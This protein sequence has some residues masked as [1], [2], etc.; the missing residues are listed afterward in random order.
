MS[1]ALV[2][3]SITAVRQSQPQQAGDSGD[4]DLGRVSD[5]TA[6]D[7]WYAFGTF[8]VIWAMPADK[9]NRDS[10]SLKLAAIWGMFDKT[11]DQ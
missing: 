9:P 11:E 3:R 6:R 4:V 5:V 10:I 2:C 7:P 8:P 1:L